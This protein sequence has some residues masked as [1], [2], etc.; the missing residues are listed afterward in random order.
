MPG[1]SGLYCGFLQFQF[2]SSELL[3]R[4]SQIRSYILSRSMLYYF[5]LLFC[6]PLIAHF[7]RDD[8]SL[9]VLEIKQKWSC[10]FFL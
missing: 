7:G 9:L 10:G 8:A 5:R 4:N 6:K 3:G 1:V 2:Y